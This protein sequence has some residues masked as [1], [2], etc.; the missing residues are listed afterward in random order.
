MADARC[1]IKGEEKVEIE[2]IEVDGFIRCQSDS[3]DIDDDCDMGLN[4]DGYWTAVPVPTAPINLI[5]TPV[6]TA[7]IDST[8]TPGPDSPLTPASTISL[9]PTA[10][11]YQPES[12]QARA[13]FH[14]SMRV[15]RAMYVNRDIE[16]A[17]Q[18]SSTV[19]KSRKCQQCIQTPRDKSVLAFNNTKISQR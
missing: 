16:I 14:K 1:S 15:L 17:G 3:D 2:E 8:V 13:T 4:L 19:P 9:A 18:K 10:L 7:S 12:E 6:P 11:R 5:I